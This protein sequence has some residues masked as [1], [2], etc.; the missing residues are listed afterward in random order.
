[1][2]APDL[3][4]DHII[5]DRPIEYKNNSFINFRGEGRIGSLSVHGLLV[6]LVYFLLVY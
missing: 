2:V 3:S 5:N 4:T 6:C 1:M